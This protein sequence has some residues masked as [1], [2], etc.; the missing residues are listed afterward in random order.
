MNF[1]NE[2]ENA[3]LEGYYAALEEAGYDLEDEV[4]ENDEMENAFMEGYYAA[5]NEI[6]EPEPGYRDCLRADRADLKMFKS[7][8][9]KKARSL[10]KG[11]RQL[12]HTPIKMKKEHEKEMAAIRAKYGINR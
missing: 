6:S 2:M 3:Y 12:A 4:E 8:N 5:L 11:S 9:A 7:I 10:Y 1:E